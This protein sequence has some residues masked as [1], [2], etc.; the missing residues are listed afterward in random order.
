MLKLKFTNA[1]VRDSGY[2]LE[3]NGTS[4][5]DIISTALGTKVGNR[6]G[7]GSGLPDFLSNCCN[8]TVIIDP[9][10][11]TTRIE[12]DENV[13]HTVKE[14]EEDAVERYE[15]YQEENTKADTEE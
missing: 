10:P 14:L 6:N 8:V 1:V 7:Y 15:Q 3:I 11:V 4:L 12:D 9:Q 5:A 2:G 13:Y